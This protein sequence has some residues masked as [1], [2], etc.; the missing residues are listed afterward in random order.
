MWVLAD[1]AGVGIAAAEPGGVGAAASRCRSSAF[2]SAFAGVMP[3]ADRAKVV[4]RVIVS[5]SDVVY[6]GGMPAA[7]A[8][9]H[10]YLTAGSV[11]SKYE[12]ANDRP[13]VRRK[14]IAAIR[15]FPS[16][17]DHL[18]ATQLSA[19]G[20]SETGLDQDGDR[21]RSTTA[22]DGGTVVEPRFLLLLPV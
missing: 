3:T 1:S 7:R 4:E 22:E 2:G 8:A 15:S 19:N 10:R 20:G 18:Q 21:R 9:G 16:Y 6:I 13:P 12:R 17:G 11:T 14:A 5:G